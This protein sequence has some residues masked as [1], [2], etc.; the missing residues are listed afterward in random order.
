LERGYAE[1][2]SFQ[3]LPFADH[4]KP[5]VLVSLHTGLRRG[6]IFKICWNDIDW[7]QATPSL[8]VRGN[9]TK[10]GK[11]R[12]IPL[13]RTASTTL[14][15][16]MSQQKDTTGLVFPSIDGKPFNTIKNSWGTVI[17]EAKIT[18]FR[19]HDLRHTFAS[20]LVMRGQQLNTVRDL[21]GHKSLEMT[22]RYAHL[23]PSVKA[24]AVA[25]LDE[26]EIKTA[27]PNPAI[28][29]A[30]ADREQAL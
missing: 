7:R 12:N 3:N 18:D 14:R 17:E 23:S 16:W 24:D 28:I 15:Q 26:A 1:F 13:N 20:R 9:I 22:L 25:V 2:P 21:L 11:T 4:L 29:R 30:V 8:R 5:M 10:N 6:E 19:W 27:Y